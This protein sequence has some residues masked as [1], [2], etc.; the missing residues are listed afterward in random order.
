M[1]PVRKSITA[2]ENCTGCALCANICPREAISMDWNRDGFLVPIV[3]NDA[4][5]D[6]G[7]CVKQCPALK[8][9][10][11]KDNGAGTFCSTGYAAWSTDAQIL[12]ESSSGGVFSEMAGF[13]IQQGGCVYGVR[14]EENLRARF[15]RIEREEEIAQFRGSKYV[16]AEPGMAYRQVLMDLRTGRKVLFAGTPCQVHALNV[17]LKKEYENLITVSLACHG[18]PSRLLAER[19]VAEHEQKERCRMTGWQFRNK[20][21][22]W[23]DF[24]T[25]NEYS[26]GKVRSRLRHKDDYMRVFLADVAMKKACFS[27]AHSY[28]NNAVPEIGDVALGDFWNVRK[29]HPGWDVFKGIST[30]LCH[31]TKGDNLIRA[32][33]DKGKLVVHKEEYG[34]AQ[35]PTQIM[36]GHDDVQL[37]RTLSSRSSALKMLREKAPMKKILKR[38]EREVLI[39]GFYVSEMNP[40]LRFLVR[41]RKWM[42]HKP[43]PRV[44]ILTESLFSNYGGLLQA[45]AMQRVVKEQGYDAFT[46]QYTD[47]D[48]SMLRRWM[49]F[50][51]N[52]LAEAL[53]RCRLLPPFPLPRRVQG[54]AGRQFI[55][56][57][58]RRTRLLPMCVM[59]MLEKRYEFSRVI[60]GSDQVWNS[61]S[62]P[63]PM[64]F[65]YL[66]WASDD[67]RKRSISYAASFGRNEIAYPE[68][69]YQKCAQ[70]LSQFRAVSTREVSGIGL[71]GK[72]GVL[73]CRQPDP[74]LLLSFDVYDKIISD[75][76]SVPVAD[77][78]IAL[79]LL[80]RCETSDGI[81]QKVVSAMK[82]DVF[83]MNRRG[84]YTPPLSVAQWLRVI[85]DSECLITDSFHGCVFAII[86]NT[87]FVCL[88]NEGRGN[89][90]FDTLLGIFG[91]EERMLTNPAPEK[92]IQVLHTPIDWYRVNAIRAAER[93]RGLNFLKKNMV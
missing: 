57:H 50:T 14:W 48:K 36:L 19:Y 20:L 24:L 26:N 62:K 78:T 29:Y 67:L 17:Y 25:V 31:S 11:A 43:K 47:T 68:P 91:L 64:P 28:V 86:Y 34:V 46:I 22:G 56:R 72:M 6:C 23:V 63:I 83:D 18:V 73:A 40:V 7:V 92:V 84:N 82:R 59:P 61:A 30:V 81:V 71:C 75:A 32:L 60:V 45:F 37:K 87:P 88:G 39:S 12:R 16:Q 77:N 13:I 58:I 80:D 65:F 52:L 55:S 27:C 85:R 76:G 21:N 15:H 69:E 44:G 93:E 5:V 2:P 49:T 33:A 74:T 41:L 8:S 38:T 66:N 3:N 70:L 79:Y 1:R 10:E 89:A 53:W 4:C 54:A 90:R 9:N 51:R 35:N 42:A